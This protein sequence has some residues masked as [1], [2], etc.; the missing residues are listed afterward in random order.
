MLMDS[1][2]GDWLSALAVA[3]LLG[4]IMSTMDSQLL[5]LGSIVERDLLGLRW[6][7]SAAGGGAGDGRAAALPAR[8]TVA[9]LSVAGYLLAL[10]PPTTIL[11]IATE[12]FAGLAVLFP[13]VVAAIYWRRATAAWSIASIVAGEVMVVLYHFGWIPTAGLLPVIPAVAVA[14]AVLLVGG[15][16]AGGAGELPDDWR[17]ASR[18]FTSRTRR[19]VWTLVCV[20]FFALSVD[21]WAFREAP[22]LLWG[23]P[24]WV[25]Y[26]L[27]LCFLLAAG[28]ALLSRAVTC[29]ADQASRPPATRSRS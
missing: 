13:T 3:G 5:T 26:F 7:P 16:A 28:Y 22:S 24:R 10:R 8:A 2:G 6:T 25:F 12:T 27:G 4:A 9:I 11:A 23:L 19:L 18:I 15:L 29:D 17:A 21:W 20:A 14:S 1:L